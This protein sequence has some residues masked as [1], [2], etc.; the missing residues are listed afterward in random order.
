MAAIY[1]GKYSGYTSTFLHNL[2]LVYIDRINRLATRSRLGNQIEL[3]NL[4][5]FLLTAYYEI[6][7]DYYDVADNVDTNFFNSVELWDVVQHFNNIAGSNL[8]LYVPESKIPVAV[9]A[10]YATGTGVIT[11]E[12]FIATWNETTN[13]DGTPVTGYYLDVATDLGFTSYVAGYQNKDMG[14]L[15]SQEV[16]GLTDGTPYYY[17]VRAYNTVKTSGNSNVVTMTTVLLSPPT[18]L[19]SVNHGSTYWVVTWTGEPLAENY[20]LDL[21]TDAGFTSYVAPHQ[22][23]NIGTLLGKSFSGLSSGT[24]YYLRIRSENGINISNNSETLTVTTD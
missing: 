19:T 16:M 21:C 13:S 8:I 17:R 2:N 3:L 23:E 10:P 14:L 4:K 9:R 11:T 22:D 6:I 18:A 5:A 7:L 24:P 15:T 1:L 20:R 12:S